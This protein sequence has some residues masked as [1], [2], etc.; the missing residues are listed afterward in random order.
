[1]REHDACGIGFVADAHGRPSHRV[2]AAALEGLA[3]VKHRGATAA[4]ARSSD[5]TGVLLPI[6]AAIFGEGHGVASLMVRDLDGAQVRARVAAAAAAE[7]IDI[8]DWRTPPVDPSVLGEIAASTRPELLQA[9]LAP[10][11]EGPVPDAVE[12]ERRAYRLRRRVAPPGA[13]TGIYVS[14]CSFRT[15]VYKGLVAADAFGAFF[16]DLLDDRV[17]ASFTIFHPVSY[18][19]LTLP[20]ILRV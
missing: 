10:S 2:V 7:G 1:M 3:G 4:D 12:L 11:G 20:T 15:V 6:P 19:H 5:G 13:A 16:L 17:E 8:V 14:S 9:V 18:T